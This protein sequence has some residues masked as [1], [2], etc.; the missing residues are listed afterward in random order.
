MLFSKI[1]LPCLAA[2]AL[3]SGFCLEFWTTLLYLPA[4]FSPY[5]GWAAWELCL[6]DFS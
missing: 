3:P 1:L 4:G 5:S 6:I 2:R